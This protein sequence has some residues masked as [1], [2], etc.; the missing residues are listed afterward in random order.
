MAPLTRN[1]VGR[2]AVPTD[3]MLTNYNDRSK[4]PGTLIIA[5]A[6]LVSKEVGGEPYIPG[7]YSSDQ[8]KS[9]K[10]IVQKVHQNKSFIFIQLWGIGRLANPKLLKEKGIEY[11][12]PSKIYFN[13]Y[14]EL[15]K[16]SGNELKEL[17]IEEIYKIKDNFI[18]ASINCC[19]KAGADGIEIHSC[20]GY[21]LDQFLQE[22]SNKRDDLYGGSDIVNRSRLL[23]EIIGGIGEK[24]GYDKIGLR[25]SPWSTGGGMPGLHHPNPQILIDQYVYILKKLQKMAD[26]GKKIA[27]ISMIESHINGGPND[28][29]KF[30]KPLDRLV[31][32]DWCL[33]H[34][35]GIVIRTNAYYWDEPE[36]D[37]LKKDLAKDKDE[38]TLIGIGTPFISNPDLV[39]RLKNGY[40]L[41][42]WDTST[43]ST[44][45][46][47]GYNTWNTYNSNKKYNKQHELKKFGKPLIKF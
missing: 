9:W 39:N 18:Q 1:R 5:E 28:Y 38:R 37:L 35:K 16:R 36:Y 46:N 13:D 20:Y 33:K 25:L 47:W 3:L 17:T 40:P 14:L 29:K 6:T 7:I 21:L 43:F 34:W 12:A 8:I 23:F 41:N 27:Y 44:Q 2:D 10:M 19:D 30:N 22:V 15:A 4:Y 26:N 31:L 32:N 11:K 42:D 45:S 24:I